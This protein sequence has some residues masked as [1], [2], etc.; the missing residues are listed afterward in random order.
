MGGRVMVF[1]DTPQVESA[2]PAAKLSFYQAAYQ[3]LMKTPSG[4][5]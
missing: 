4:T 3:R 2:S 1:G 5:N